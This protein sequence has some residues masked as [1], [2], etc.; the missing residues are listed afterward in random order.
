MNVE[1]K[2]ISSRIV[3]TSKERQEKA[4]VPVGM[5]MNIPP[6]PQV[7]M[8]VMKKVRMKPPT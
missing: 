3:Q 6:H 8:K 5:K 7:E 2:G 4:S 1:E